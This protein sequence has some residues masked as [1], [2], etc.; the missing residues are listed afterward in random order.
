MTDGDVPGARS[1]SARQHTAARTRRWR[2]LAGPGPQPGAKRAPGPGDL[3][4]CRGL[5]SSSRPFPAAPHQPFNFQLDLLLSHGNGMQIGPGGLPGASGCDLSVGPQVWGGYTH[6]SGAASGPWGEWVPLVPRNGAAAQE[7]HPPQLPTGKQILGMVLAMLSSMTDPHSPRLL[8][9]HALPWPRHPA[10]TGSVP[11]LGPPCSPCP[12]LAAVGERSPALAGWGEGS[13]SPEPGKV[14]Q[15]GTARLPNVAICLRGL[16][17]HLPGVQRGQGGRG[18]GGLG[19]QLQHGEGAKGAQPS[20]TTQAAHVGQIWVRSVK[21]QRRGPTPSNP[22]GSP[23]LQMVALGKGL[24][25]LAAP[26]CCQIKHRT[27]PIPSPA[28]SPSLSSSPWVARDLSCPRTSPSPSTWFF[29][30][31]FPTPRSPWAPVLILAGI[32]LIFSIGAGMGLV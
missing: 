20:P 6:L 28:L 12:A 24:I 18:S 7:H 31:C 1:L 29:W 9:P 13:W 8:T 11:T 5:T 26:F 21:Q 17:S 23:V 3:A 16:R 19:A 10:S 2:L 15:P 14:P 30:I 22:L 32:E 4:L 27:I 25:S